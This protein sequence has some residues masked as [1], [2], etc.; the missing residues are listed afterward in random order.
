[1][2]IGNFFGQSS[3]RKSDDLIHTYVHILTHILIF[4]TKGPS[5]D[6]LID[7]EIWKSFPDCEKDTLRKR[8]QGN[9]AQRIWSIVDRTGIGRG[10][11]Q[12]SQAGAMYN[13]KTRHTQCFSC[14]WAASAKDVCADR[15]KGSYI[16]C[17][18]LCPRKFYNLQRLLRKKNL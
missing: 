15:A 1:M 8:M 10:N 2:L 5:G 13:L 4:P 6:F 17:L 9:N 7:I 16:V 12:N 3:A 14:G 11:L 18:S